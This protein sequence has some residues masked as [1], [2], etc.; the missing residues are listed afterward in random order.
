M[1]VNF[2]ILQY[3][4]GCMGYIWEKL[5]CLFDSVCRLQLTLKLGD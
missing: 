3:T 1:V 2:V 5:F 4:M